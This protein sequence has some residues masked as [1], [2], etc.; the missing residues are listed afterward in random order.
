[1]RLI[2]AVIFFFLCLIFTNSGANE[3]SKII[4]KLNNINNIQ[5]KFS[6]KTNGNIEKGKCVLAFPGKLKCNYEDKNKKELVVNKKIMAI[7]QKR[8]GKTLFYPLAKSTFLNILGK[9]ELINIV[10]ENDSII[11]DY[12][13][14]VFVDDNNFK[15]LIKFGKEDFLLSGWTSSDQYNNQIIFDIEITSINQI[16][17][18]DIF[19]LPSKN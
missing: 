17:D 11:G 18:D 1:L 14:I 7:T 8:Y 19:I 12:I 5:F 13:Y 2:K 15:T 10:N 6:Q 9:R 3:K 4:N 16:I